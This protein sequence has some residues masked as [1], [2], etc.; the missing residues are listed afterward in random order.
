MRLGRGG[1]NELD[2][3][4]TAIFN[5]TKSQLNGR[6]PLEALDANWSPEGKSRKVQRA[7]R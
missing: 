1:L 3:Q 4:A 7:T 2:V 6:T 5:N